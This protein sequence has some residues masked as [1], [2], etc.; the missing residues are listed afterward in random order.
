METPP[1]EAALV[2][3]ESLPDGTRSIVRGSGDGCRRPTP[4]NAVYA[5]TTEADLAR[6]RL[7]HALVRR[8]LFASVV[9]ACFITGYYQLIGDIEGRS[10]VAVVLQNIALTGSGIVL[11]TSFVGRRLRTAYEPEWARAEET[12]PVPD[13]LRDALV[14]QPERLARLIF[15]L[16]IVGAAVGAADDLLD[17]SYKS[18]AAEAVGILLGALAHAALVYLSTERLLRSVFA[19]ALADGGVRRPASVGIN[20]RLTAA[21]ALGSGVPLLG[22]VVTPLVRHPG[23]SFSATVA[24]VYLGVIGLV[25]GMLMVR[26]AARSVAEPINVVRKGL[27]RI[28][29]GDLAADVAVDDAGEIGAL[30]TGFNEMARGLR[31]RALIEDLFGRHVGVEVSRLA[32]EQGAVRLGGE[33]RDV[34]VFFVDLIGSTGMAETSTPQ[35]VMEI[36]NRFFASVVAAVTEEGGWVDKF[37]GDGAL[38]VF[39]APAPHADHAARGLRAARALER[40]LCS[41]GIAAGIGVSSG[42]VVAGN[43][44]TE[45]RFEYTVIGH[46]VNEAAR[47]TE[48]AKERDVRLVAA[49]VTV[50]GAGVGG[51]ADAG[52]VELRG[53]TRPTAISVPADG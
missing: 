16:W 47:L 48:L 28:E 53:T 12:T 4:R 15:Q 50:V 17:R 14:R 25:L 45:A 1:Q 41:V 11:A 10:R 5:G 31:E 9:A 24:M 33:N 44:G 18:A 6:R 26:A 8:V 23:A 36:V 29:V 30:Q 7:R 32:L 35:Q 40:D 21:W 19:R 38:C 20:A 34:T 22:I 39:G 52:T 2:P 27:T 3:P 51:W 49:R 43:V 46:P 13:D 42:T 37:E